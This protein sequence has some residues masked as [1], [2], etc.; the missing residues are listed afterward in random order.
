MI[1]SGVAVTAR[2]SFLNLDPATQSGRT[3]TQKIL[4]IIKLR[5]IEPIPKLDKRQS[6]SEAFS[7]SRHLDIVNPA[8]TQTH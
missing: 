8:S 7:N 5:L 6:L 3:K 4:I 1:T 2:L